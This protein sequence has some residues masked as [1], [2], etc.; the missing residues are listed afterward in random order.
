MCFR[1]GQGHQFHE[2]TGAEFTLDSKYISSYSLGQGVD[3]DCVLTMVAFAVQFK[4][5]QLTFLL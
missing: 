3:A 4:A 5:A 2:W 1:T